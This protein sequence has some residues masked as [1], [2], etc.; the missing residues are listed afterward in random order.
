MKKC[1]VSAPFGSKV[2]EFGEVNFDDVFD[3]IRGAVTERGYQC[4][5]ADSLATG[6]I[7]QRA[8]LSAIIDSDLMIADLSGRNPNVLYELGLRHAACTK[9]TIILVNKFERI[10]HSLALIFV[11]RYSMEGERLSPSEAEVLRRALAGALEEATAPSSGRFGSPVKE[12][13][14]DLLGSSPKEPCVFIGHGRSAL[15]NKIQVMLTNDYGVR[16]IAYESESRTGESIT[17]ILEEMLAKATFAVLVLTAED[18]VLDGQKRARQN[19]VHEAGLFQGTLGFRRAIILHQ[20]GLE[21]FSNVSGI[22]YIAF[23]GESIEETFFEL[24]RVLKRERII[25]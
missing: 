5:R 10:P 13:F 7:I 17:D 3:T 2:L 8:I 19:V 14:P 9:P 24:Q 22:Q 1:Y 6:G 15:W 23:A 20:K 18:E 21:D 16:V 25:G 4:N 11:V 12:F